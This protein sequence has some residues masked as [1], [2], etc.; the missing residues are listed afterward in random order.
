MG[1]PEQPLDDRRLRAL[2]AAAE[3]DRRRWAREL[4]DQTLQALAVL[5]VMLSSA[6]RSG[7]LTSLA[8][9]LELIGTEIDNV[10][11]LITELWPTLLDELGVAPAL[12]ALFERTR[13]THGIPIDATLE[14]SHGARDSEDR[15]DSE[16]ETVLYRV[17]EEALDNAIRHAEPSTVQVEVRETE[18][19]VTA[20]V[21][22]DG[23]GFDDSEP[24][25][26]VGLAV[27]RAHVALAGGTLDIASSRT[28]TK[29][30]AKLPIR[31]V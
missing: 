5:R 8:E 12:E 13:A 4:H 28:G 1:Q 30:E 27:L 21:R 22:D 11:A 15:F 26:G 17:I 14:L 20:T 10:R 2:I 18:L 23:G 9:A 6:Q 3:S 7:D 24:T 16:F 29:V 19:G 25:S 31:P